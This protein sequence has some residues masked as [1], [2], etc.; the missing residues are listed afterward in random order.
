MDSQTRLYVTLV[1]ISGIFN[2]FLC[3]YVFI[4][5]RE[6]PAARP[7]FFYTLVLTIYSL[8]YTFELSSDTI[9]E[10]KRWTIIEYVGIAT[11]APLAFMIILHYLGRKITRAATAALFVIPAV[12]WVMVAT[13]DYHPWYYKSF[14]FKENA[15]PHVLEVVS[16]QWYTVHDLFMF[17][18]TVA[19]VVLLLR[20]WKQTRKAYRLQLFTLICGQLIP[21]AAGI[22]Y[23]MG[24]TPTGLDPVPMS[25]CLT[26]ALYI[27]AIVSTRM[28]TVIPI[29][30]ESIFDSMGEGFIVLDSSGRL[31]DYNRAVSRMIHSH[32]RPMIGQKL[33]DVWP[34]LTESLLPHRSD[35][36]AAVEVLAWTTEG[37]EQVYEVRSSILRQRNGEPAGNLLLLINVT[38]LKRL[39]RELEQQAFYDGLTQIYNR[40]QFMSRGRELLLQCREQDKPFAVI[41][42]DIDYFKR[43]NDTYGHDTGDK[44]IV[45]VVSVCK[46]ALADDDLFARYGGEEFVLALPSRTLEQAGEVAERLRTVMEAA[47]LQTAKG[48]L[49]VTSSFGVAESAIGFEESLDALLRRADEAL[50]ASKH[51]GRNRVSV[52][53]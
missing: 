36:D 32:G 44:L 46:Q 1:G 13:S 11:F 12:T 9:Q 17:S 23:R 51:G 43:V 18:C 21:M 16:G 52:S 26:S 48:T 30:K 22:V 20:R 3:L 42:F 37:A 40:A 15:T 24:V 33:D 29:A 39:Q 53:A 27:W 7:F 50:Y 10:V 41:L 49:A 25:M 45:H 4:R 14:G 31:I 34:E 2:L 5:R 28:L 19:G 6:I 8:G 35:Q 47:P 38:E